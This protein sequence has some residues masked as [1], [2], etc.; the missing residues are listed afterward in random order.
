GRPGDFPL[1]GDSRR[2]LCRNYP[3]LLSSGRRRIQHAMRVLVQT[4]ERETPR[5]VPRMLRTRSVECLASRRLGPWVLSK[6]EPCRPRRRFNRPHLCLLL[7]LMLS[8][9]DSC[10]KVQCDEFGCGTAQNNCDTGQ[11]AADC[12]VIV[13]RLDKGCGS[14][15]QQATFVK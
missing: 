3:A 8:G 12:I 1:L 9:C 7:V 10:D 15:D 13:S 6:T 4:T 14:K 5:R 11:T 2:P